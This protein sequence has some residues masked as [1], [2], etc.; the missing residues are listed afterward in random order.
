MATRCVIVQNT[1]KQMGK[2]PKSRTLRIILRILKII[3]NSR[4]FRIS[5]MKSLIL[6]IGY[7]RRHYHHHAYVVRP[8]G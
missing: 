2:T 1:R 3:K 6:D 5:K 7:R 8:L 4:F